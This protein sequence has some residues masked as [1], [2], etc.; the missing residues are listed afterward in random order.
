MLKAAVFGYFSVREEVATCLDIYGCIS[1]LGRRKERNY[2]SFESTQVTLIGSGSCKI[3]ALLV[4]D[5]RR[6]STI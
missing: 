6:L 3:S 2:G 5:C 1:A 4:Y